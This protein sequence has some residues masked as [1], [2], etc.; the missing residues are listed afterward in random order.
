MK[1]KELI[2][3]IKLLLD[4]VKILGTILLVVVL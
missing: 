3:M 1:K 4:C 2:K